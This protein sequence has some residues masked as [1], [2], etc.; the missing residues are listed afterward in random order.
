[1]TKKKRTTRT[2]SIDDGIY[3]KFVNIINDNNLNRSK[4]IE[5]L[6]VEYLEKME[7]EVK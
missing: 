5:S 3:N 2:Y 6:I 1:M 4:V 7:K